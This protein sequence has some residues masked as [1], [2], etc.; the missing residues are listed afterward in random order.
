MTDQSLDKPFETI[1]DTVSKGL[2]VFKDLLRGV[3]DT[4]KSGDDAVSE[5]DR[6]IKSSGSLPVADTSE[7]TLINVLQTMRSAMEEAK[8]AESAQSPEVVSRAKDILKKVLAAEP[9]WR[10]GPAAIRTANDMF[11][12]A[13][14]DLRS[15]QSLLKLAGGKGELEDL[16]S[17]INWADKISVRLDSI[18]QVAAEPKV[19]KPEVAPT[20]SAA[21]PK[22]RKKTV[23]K[24]KRET[25]KPAE[26]TPEVIFA[27]AIAAE[28]NDGQ[29][30]GWAKEFAD[31]K[32]TEKVWIQRLTDHAAKSVDNLDDI[33]EKARIRLEKE[34][35]GAGS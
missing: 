29:V 23:R 16:D 7:T 5:L 22:H 30:T 19:P 24:K 15:S 34:A 21:P 14:R 10:P 6:T 31:G 18:H 25:G 8:E 20:Q 28:M 11:R 4:I 12:V 33:F 9:G 35:K 32:I 26:Q 2:I 13:L 1:Q 17:L 27:Q 3:A